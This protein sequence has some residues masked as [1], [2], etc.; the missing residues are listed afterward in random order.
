[1]NRNWSNQKANPAIN[2]KPRGLKK[3]SK[4]GDPLDMKPHVLT[5]MK[6]AVPVYMLTSRKTKLDLTQ[7]EESRGEGSTYTMC[8][9]TCGDPWTAKH[10]HWKSDANGNGE[11][12][13]LCQHP[14][15]TQCTAHW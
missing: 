1:M 3:N 15:K 4:M 8:C 5:N 10:Y 11:T 7:D 12:F 14:I 13:H 2:V 6:Q 9:L